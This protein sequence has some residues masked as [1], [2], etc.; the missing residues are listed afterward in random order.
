MEI[1]HQKT[2]AFHPDIYVIGGL[3][4]IN[5]PNALLKYIYIYIT[6]FYLFIK[7]LLIL[8]HISQT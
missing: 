6:P 7:E 5:E 2:L 8:L 3:Q 1:F 4:L